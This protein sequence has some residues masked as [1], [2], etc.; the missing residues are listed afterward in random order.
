[1][2][3]LVISAVSFFTLYLVFHFVN[4][5]NDEA[6]VSQLAPQ[7]EEESAVNLAAL[8][9]IAPANSSVYIL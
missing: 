2:Y 9:S 7:L 1:M 8:I 6:E 5:R 4:H 3:K